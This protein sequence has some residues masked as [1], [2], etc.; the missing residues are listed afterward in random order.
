MVVYHLLRKTGWSTVVA[1]GTRQIVNRKFPRGCARSI[2]KTF[3]QKI[4][5][6]AIQAKRPGTNTVLTNGTHILHLKIPS[7]NFSLPFKKSRFLEKISVALSVRGHR[8]IPANCKT[9]WQYVCKLD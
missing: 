3:S 2:S 1:N 8:L 6:K 5:S 4:G 7:G 9:T